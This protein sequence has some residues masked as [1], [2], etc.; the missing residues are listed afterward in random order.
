MRTNQLRVVTYN[1][2][3]CKGLDGRVLPDRVARVLRE[4]DADI[5]ALQEVVSLPGQAP[6]DDQA[7]YLARELQAD[8]LFG[9]NRRLWGGAYGNVV[10]SRLPMRTVKNHDLSVRGRERRGCLQID[11]EIAK[12]KW[13]HGQDDDVGIPHKLGVVLRAARADVGG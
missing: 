7:H 9:E 13:P 3:R 11:V 6:E 12:L 1:V 8:F 10:M 5:V 4:V 2:H